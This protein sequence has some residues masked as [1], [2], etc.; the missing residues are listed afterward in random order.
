[1]SLWQPIN[2]ITAVNHCQ[3]TGAVFRSYTESAA[4]CRT[5]STLLCRTYGVVPVGEDGQLLLQSQLAQ[6]S[7]QADIQAQAA[8]RTPATQSNGIG[9][10]RKLID[11]GSTAWCPCDPLVTDELTGSQRQPSDDSSEARQFEK[12]ERTKFI[13]HIL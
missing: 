13:L 4:D 6:E 1:M 2:A 7:G 3:Y 12:T 11:C 9:V 8:V 5:D 10:I